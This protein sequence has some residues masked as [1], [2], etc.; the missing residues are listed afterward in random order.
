MGAENGGGLVFDRAAISTK[1]SRLVKVYYKFALSGDYADVRK[2]LYS[3]ETATEFVVVER[4]ELAQSP[5]GTN[6]NGPLNLIVM[7]ATYYQS[8][9]P[10]GSATGTAGQGQGTR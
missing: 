9:A 10:S 4:V 5:L 7:V 8:A 3:L 6:T 1:D 2:F